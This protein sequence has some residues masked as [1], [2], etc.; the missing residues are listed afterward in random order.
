MKCLSVV[1][2]AFAMLVAT[3]ASAATVVLDPSSFNSGSFSWENG[4]GPIDNINGISALDSATFGITANAGD[5]IDAWLDDCCVAG[6]QFALLLNGTALT[7]TSTTVVFGVYH[8]V[9]DDIVLA[10]GQNIFSINVTGLAPG[11]TTGGADYRFSAVTPGAVPEPGTWAMML[12]G[13]GAAGF[14]IRR[15]R[16][17]EGALLPQIA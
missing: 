15:R 9:F 13:F 14:A 11:Y 6:D 16:K 17:S 3:P 1:A 4:L 5:L 2:A 10:G 7:P 12:L 8:Y